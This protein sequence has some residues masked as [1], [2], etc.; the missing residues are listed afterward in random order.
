MTE[1]PDNQFLSVIYENTSS[2]F[3]TKFIDLGTSY[4]SNETII[5]PD[6]GLFFFISIVRVDSS[7]KVGIGSYPAILDRNSD[8]GMFYN[9]FGESDP[10]RKVKAMLSK[11]FPIVVRGTL[12]QCLVTLWRK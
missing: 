7:F 5:I 9:I 8:G 1:T 2:E 12:M 4:N 6:M 3:S 11:I 10:S